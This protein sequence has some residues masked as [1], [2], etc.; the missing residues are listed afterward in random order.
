[1]LLQKKQAVMVYGPKVITG[2]AFWPPVAIIRIHYSIE[3]WRTENDH[4]VTLLLPPSSF[5]LPLEEEDEEG[6]DQWI[7]LRGQKVNGKWM[8]IHLDNI[9]VAPE[10]SST[11]SPTHPVHVNY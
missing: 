10:S 1:M 9:W 3:W 6:I 7:L 5:P 8:G 2:G 11:D 4:S